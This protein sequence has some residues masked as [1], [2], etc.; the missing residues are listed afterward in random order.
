M[1]RV[2]P[3]SIRRAWAGRSFSSLLRSTTI[4]RTLRFNFFCILNASHIYYESKN[5]ELFCPIFCFEF[6]PNQLNCEVHSI[7]NK[8]L[9]AENSTDVVVVFPPQANEVD[10]H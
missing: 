3:I 5:T 1:G 8:S 7:D 4:A 10:T 9:L 6:S 2:D